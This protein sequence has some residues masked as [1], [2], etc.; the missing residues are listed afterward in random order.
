MYRNSGFSVLSILLVAIG[1]IGALS[2]L[3][4]KEGQNIKGHINSQKVTQLVTQSQFIIQR[5]VKCATDYP[6]G[7]NE[8]TSHKAYPLDN[9][10]GSRPVAGLVCPGNNQNLWSGVDGVYYPVPIS[11]FSNW[12]YTKAS[13]TTISI[14][15]ND[16]AVYS[17][18]IAAAAAK[19]GVSAS[20]TA[21]TL[22]VKI[23]E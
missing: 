12:V 11:G 19:I 2:F 21:D 6:N 5:I 22:T 18:A 14:K 8:T 3:L 13:P 9:N 23:I 4:L 15:A 20:A 10:P 16:P 17:S 1:L 7:D